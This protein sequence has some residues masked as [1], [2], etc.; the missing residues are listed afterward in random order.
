[1]KVHELIEQLEKMNTGAPA[2]VLILGTDGKLYDVDTPEFSHVR[3]HGEAPY[4]YDSDFPM[5]L[6]LRPT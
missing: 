6:V 2:D 5:S 4:E 3:V 1:M